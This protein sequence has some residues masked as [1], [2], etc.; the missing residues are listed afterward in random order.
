LKR[1]IRFMKISLVSL[2]LF[3]IVQLTAQVTQRNSIST[4]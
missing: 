2:F 3:V 1:Q 4:R